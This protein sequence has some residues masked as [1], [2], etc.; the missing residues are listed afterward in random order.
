MCDCSNVGNHAPEIDN[1]VVQHADNTVATPGVYP[2]CHK[3]PTCG[4]PPQGFTW[5]PWL[6]PW[7]W[8]Y[9]LRWTV[10]AAPPT[11]F[12]TPWVNVSS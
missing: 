2:T 1:T 12:T 8:Q 9:P 6:A 10:T 5:T 4:R 3:C 7:E 11:T